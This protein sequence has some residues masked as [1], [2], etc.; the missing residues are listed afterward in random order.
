MQGVGLTKKI[1]LFRKGTQYSRIFFC[2]RA[3]ELNF[4]PKR[5]NCPTMGP[6]IPLNR[7]NYLTMELN[8]PPER[9][10]Y[11]PKR[12]SSASF[13][14]MRFVYYEIA[15][16]LQA[17]R[18]FMKGKPYVLVITPR[19]ITMEYNGNSSYIPT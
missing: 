2:L 8:I 13:P 19:E 14:R 9:L 18:L 1:C 10:S 16:Y 17:Y 3:K 7:L 15:E 5:F 4:P 11:P 12:L 6:N